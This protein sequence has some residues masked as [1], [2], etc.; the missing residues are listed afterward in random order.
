MKKQ[1]PFIV[2]LGAGKKIYFLSDF[3]LG[4]P[5]AASSLQREKRIVQFLDSIKADAEQLFIVGDMFDFWFEYR[6]V[7][8]KG[9][10]RLLGKLAEFADAGVPIHF[11]VGNHDMWM[12]DYFQKELNIPVYFEP[13]PFEYQGKR[14]LIGHGDGLG[15]GDKGYKFI[16]KIFRNPTCQWLFGILPPAVGIGMADYFSRK[17][18]AQT[19]MTDEAFLGEDKEW[20]VIYSKEILKQQHFDYF[21]F[22]HRHLPLDIKLSENSRYVNLGDWIKYNSYAVFEN[23]ELSLRYNPS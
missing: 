1:Q 13:Q 7:V 22:G 2:N 15:P 9:Y 18:R 16:K 11:F 14:F 19:G 4:V 8:P 12:K 17:S 20:L 5:D 21:V 23:G 6:Y 10:V 3:H